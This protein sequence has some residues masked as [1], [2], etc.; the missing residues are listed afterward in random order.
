[1]IPLSIRVRGF[2]SYREPQEL[3]FDEDGLWVLEG[4]NGVG[5][6][7]IF[8]AITFALF[9]QHRLG[10]QHHPE[11][12]NHDS[13]SL[14][15]EL[16]LRLEDETYKLL[17]TVPRKG[18]PVFQISQRTSD[19]GFLPISGT[20]QK[21]PYHTWVQERLGL[22]YDA[23]T[24]SVLLLQGESEKLIR[25]G[26]ED[27]R[28]VL[29]KLIDLSR[30]ERLHERAKKHE[31]QHRWEAARLDQRLGGLREVRAEDVDAAEAA[32]TAAEEERGALNR[33]AEELLALLPAAEQHDRLRAERAELSG[34][35]AAQQGLLAR[36]AEIRERASELDR[37]EPTLEPLRDAAHARRTLAEATAAAA[38][39][40]AH[41]QAAEAAEQAAQEGEHAAR[42]QEEDRQKRDEAVRRRLEDLQSER[43][44]LLPVQAQWNAAE[45]MR[46]QHEQRAAQIAALPAAGE[47]PPEQ[48]L[49]AAQRVLKER[50]SE[51]AHA[52]A[53]HKLRVD[54]LRDLEALAGQMSGDA[55][56]CSL[57]GQEVTAA[58]A[59]AERSRLLE[60][61]SR[62]RGAAEAAEQAR[63][64]AE[65]EVSR[66]QQAHEVALKHAQ[67]RRALEDEQAQSAMGLVRQMQG[68]TPEE[69]LAAVQR[70][71][72]LEAL[73]TDGRREL[74]AE[75]D[76]LRAARKDT[77]I[78]T[79][80]RRQAEAAR[81][82]LERSLE[83]VRGKR[84]QELGKLE[85][86]LGQLPEALRD[87]RPDQVAATE[88]RVMAL[89]PYRDQ[90]A[91]LSEAEVGEAGRRLAEIDRQL[92]AVP[93]PARRA[94]A[95]LH[96]LLE[97]KRAA[98]D[99]AQKLRDQRAGELERMKDVRRQRADLE[100][101]RRAAAYDQQI[102]GILAF[103]LGPEELQR[104]LVR[105]AEQAIVQL[106]NQEL[107]GL[108]QGRLRLALRPGKD[109]EDAA[110]KALD[111]LV[112]NRET[113]EQP[114][115]LLL[116]SG[117]QKF[118]IAISLALAI[119]RY[120]ARETRRVESVII[121]E[122]F[123]CL[124]RASRE[125]AVTVLRELTGHLSRVILVSH[126]EEFS[127][128]FKSGYRI[129]LVDRTSV[130]TRVS[131]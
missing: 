13:D 10:K 90:A 114:T 17:R 9:G 15:V 29:A 105:D 34:R 101:A 64:A 97:E 127:G 55:V 70:L 122:G 25:Q 44:R 73:L 108:T 18:R 31:E 41:V 47:E 30:Y 76:A 87:A 86:L 104:R 24:T 23:F 113:S 11:L 98:R 123:G 33:V 96:A 118:R 54:R 42:Q 60:D 36:A 40:E 110:Q 22:D 14:E 3:R 125:D 126:E 109:G 116:A 95:E 80:R 130:P 100:E 69:A 32:L 92:D 20:E 8:D 35:L 112:C 53:E 78:A 82:A 74:R 106:A 39:G 37:V 99:T 62:L 45:E 16:V 43:D 21:D 79:D 84:Q 81:R 83:G 12:I 1:M 66:A 93:E 71:A 72:E 94:V 7:T 52:R 103:L 85:V 67:R 119:G 117:S 102:Y 61:T 131:R 58:H 124:D 2:M 115:A 56:T 50:Q 19:G 4:P 38:T 6:S 27:R 68:L 89:R 59:Q 120:L 63:Q 129:D 77:T 49:T 51:E 107:T 28:K 46:R 128:R 48:A 91:Q 65:G 121:D 88:E 5:K 26:P 57:C 111:L 75:Q